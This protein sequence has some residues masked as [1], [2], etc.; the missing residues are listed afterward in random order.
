MKCLKNYFVSRKYGKG[1]IS[2]FLMFI[3]FSYVFLLSGVRSLSKLLLFSKLFSFL[4]FCKE[5]QGFKNGSKKEGGL[6]FLSSLS[7]G[8]ILEVRVR[9]GEESVKYSLLFFLF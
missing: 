3:E 7:L 4:T 9:K 5:F 1:M 8:V 2:R 6:G